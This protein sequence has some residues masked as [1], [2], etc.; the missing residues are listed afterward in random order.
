MCAIF[1][2]ISHGPKPSLDILGDIVHA[3]I[4]RG[5]HSFGF[6]WIDSLGRLRH[7]KQ[8]GNLADRTNMPFLNLLADARM[9][10]GHLRYFTHGSPDNNIN[11]H[12]HA[13]DGGWLVHNGVISNYGELLRRDD[14]WPVSDCDSETIGLLMELSAEKHL[15]DRARGAL[16]EIKGGGFAAMGLWRHPRQM[17]A[18]RR[19]NPLHITDGREGLYMGSLAEG[20]PGDVRAMRDNTMCHFVIQKRKIDTKVYAI[21]AGVAHAKR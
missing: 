17:L 15:V 12:P 2:F 10:I 13:C 20:L 21:D 6:A 5:P 7:Y 16:S 18:I 3:N 1:G 9:A 4:C 8:K 14:M 19:G 11:N